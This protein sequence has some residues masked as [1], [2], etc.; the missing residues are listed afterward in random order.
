[1]AT[2]YPIRSPN[3]RGGEL[4]ISPSVLREGKSQYKGVDFLDDAK[5]DYVD[6]IVKVE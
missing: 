1:M 5:N 4:P 2:M 6:D 3:T